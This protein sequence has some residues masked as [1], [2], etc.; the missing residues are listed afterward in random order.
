MKI[1]WILFF[2]FLMVLG[3]SEDGFVDDMP[4][5]YDVD[6][7]F[8]PYVQEFVAEAAKRGQN[9]NFRETGL[10]VKFSELP[11]NNANGRCFLGQ[12]R[13]EIDKVDWFSF[14]E[15]FRSY[16]LFHELGHCALNRRHLNDQFEDG[17]WRSVLKGNP[18]IEFDARKPVP[19]FGFRIDYY[20]NELFDE[21]IP[22]PEWSDVTFDFNQ[23]IE[24]EEV[25]NL[26][27]ETSRL[28]SRLSDFT[29]DYEIEVEFDLIDTRGI[30]T[31]LEWG[32]SGA[33]YYIQMIPDFGY[34]IG[35]KDGGV[36][37][38]LHYRQDVDSA[39]GRL[40]DKITIRQSEGFEQIFVNE[41]FVFHLDQQSRLDFV[42]LSALMGDQ[43]VNTF[44]IQELTISSIN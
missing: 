5:I 31:T 25:L 20:I 30:W 6:E 33:N 10:S 4:A 1:N 21:N 34:Y 2:S 29:D 39:N 37:N 16:L 40:I 14:S 13:I 3:C 7:E 42:T 23:P 38:I 28:N 24:R 9:F 8:E 41:E 44:N 19:Y 35:V 17:S 43:V 36:D 27:P 18:F 12:Y 32:A 26:I 15:L 22:S 11:L